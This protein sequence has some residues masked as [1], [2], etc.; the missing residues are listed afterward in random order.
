MPPRATLPNAGA[1]VCTLSGGPAARAGWDVGPRGAD[2][3]DMCGRG[4]VPHGAPSRPP[5]Q[6][7]GWRRPCV[8]SMGSWGDRDGGDGPGRRAA[9]LGR[10]RLRLHLA[11]LPGSGGSRG[12][13]ARVEGG[14]DASQDAAGVQQGHG[15]RQEGSGQLQSG[16]GGGRART[17]TRGLLLKVRT[18]TSRLEA[19]APRAA[20][21]AT[22]RPLAAGAGRRGA[23]VQP[24]RGLV[25]A[26][27]SPRRS[28]HV[29][30]DAPL[31]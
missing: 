28:D 21:A 8:R 9:R 7:R 20:G 2:V 22:Q 24:S 10:P 11:G 27:P 23:S 13:E 5:E 18:A 4:L 6:P 26:H 29:S 3:G 31:T 17:P 15:G 16:A 25:R 19:R 1:R 12:G 30:R 14:G